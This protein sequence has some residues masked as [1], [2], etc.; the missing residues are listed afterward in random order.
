MTSQ[1]NCNLLEFSICFS[2]VLRCRSTFDLDIIYHQNNHKKKENVLIYKPKKVSKSPLNLSAQDLS[3]DRTFLDDFGIS[4]VTHQYWYYM[5]LYIVPF[6]F[7][8]S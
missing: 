1:L 3:N 5:G 4:S 7:C 2:T 6:D 8:S